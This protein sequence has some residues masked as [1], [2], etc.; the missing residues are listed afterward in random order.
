MQGKNVKCI[1]SVTRKIGA[2]LDIPLD[3]DEL[4]SMSAE[5]ERGLDSV[6][7]TKKELAEHI[8]MIEEAYDKESGDSQEDLKDWFQNQGI[9]LD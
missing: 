1:S 2:L 9:R 6:V 8:K 5:F 7:E 4:D 3:L